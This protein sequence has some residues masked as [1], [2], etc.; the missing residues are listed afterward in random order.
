VASGG[1]DE[2][3]DLCG[4]LSEALKFDYKEKHSLHCFLVCDSP[5]H[6]E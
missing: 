6:G 2:A 5:C 1:G 3:E 4:A